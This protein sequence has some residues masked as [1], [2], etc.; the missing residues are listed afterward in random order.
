V[1][2]SFF[3]PL[4]DGRWRATEHTVG[5]WD[6]GTQHGGP[7]S[8]LLGRAI[9][10]CSPRDDMIISRFT[11]EILG[12]VPVGE[13]DVEARVIRPGRSVEL[14]EA[15]LTAAAASRPSASARAWRVLRTEGP[16]VPAAPAPA[17][18]LPGQP[19]SRTPPG[20]VDGYLSAIEWRPVA[21]EFGVPGPAT[22][23]A[24]QRCPLVP[25]EEP[26]PLQRVLTVADSGNGLANELDIRKWRFIN[27]ELTVHLY[28]DAVAE[29][30]CLAAWTT[31]STNGA[32]L[33]SSVL[34]DQEGPIGTGAQTLLITPR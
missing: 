10:W 21:G 29:W 5:P 25:G 19:I 32:G 30:I 27:P 16:S 15:T 33:A 24:R 26:T 17:P 3:E 8:A 11:C 18:G 9:E 28:R 34:S 23:W 20:W 1:S 14:V 4:G 13:V 6:P 12:P 7:P 22:V 31:I 2:E